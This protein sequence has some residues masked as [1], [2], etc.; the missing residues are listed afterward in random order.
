MLDLH[1]FPSAIIQG[2]DENKYSILD[3]L[4]EKKWYRSHVYSAEVIRYALLLRHTS[5]QAYRLVR[6]QFPLPSISLLNRIQRGG[7]DSIKAL[8]LL[9]DHGEMS[10]DLIL[11]VD[12]MILQKEESYQAGT[13]IGA[14][15]NGELYKGIVCFM[16]LGLKDSVPYVV[17]AAPEVKLTGEWLK[18]K[19]D[20]NLKNLMDA[21]FRVR[22]VVTDNHSTNV[23]AFDYLSKSYSTD[24]SF[25]INHPNN[26]GKRTYFFY[27]SPHLIKN[28]RNN[29]LNGKKFVFPEFSYNDGKDTNVHCPAGYIR[30]ADLHGIHDIDKELAA[31]LRMSKLSYQVLHPGNKKQDVPLAL[32]VFDEKT[33]AAAKKYFP[34]RKDLSGFLSVF[35][36]WWRIANSRVRYGPDR[37]GNAIENGD[38][39]TDFYRALANWIK[40]WCECQYLT[41]TKQTGKA[42]IFSLQVTSDAYRR[43]P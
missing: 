35:N 25:Y 24:E 11:L 33:I 17:V 37:L 27:D 43:T 36:T 42:V 8:K 40:T 2:A 31:H 34:D 1:K 4:N 9:R 5:L 21:G 3:E 14:S 28:V 6:E 23:N 7:V 13:H 26:G 16:V 19:I 10:E 12:E 32:A 18:K 39:K 15:E 30:W 22:G 20:E 38:G 41:L 29:L